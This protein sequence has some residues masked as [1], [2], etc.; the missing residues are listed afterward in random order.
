M[1]GPQREPPVGLI[2]K[3]WLENHNVLGWLKGAFGFSPNILWTMRGPMDCAWIHFRD[4][5][6]H[7]CSS[8][9]IWRIV[10]RCSGRN[11]KRIPRCTGWSC[12]S[13]LDPHGKTRAGVTLLWPLNSVWNLL[14]F[15]VSWGW[16]SAPKN[17]AFFPQCSPRLGKGYLLEF[18]DQHSGLPLFDLQLGWL[19]SSQLHY[20]WSSSFPRSPSC[21]CFSRL[22]TLNPMAQGW[23]GLDSTETPGGQWQ[24]QPGLLDGTQAGCVR[25]TPSDKPRSCAPG[26]SQA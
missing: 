7:L 1:G 26:A 4:G 17:A 2:W 13:L 11:W 5:E 6:I 10:R 25:L 9:P 8:K 12:R 3:L 15:Q 23:L 19:P 24:G 22:C 14:E 20:S 21:P 16:A 18:L